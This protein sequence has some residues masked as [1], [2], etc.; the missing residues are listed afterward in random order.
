M[1]CKINKEARFLYFIFLILFFQKTNAAGQYLDTIVVSTDIAS[2]ISKKGILYQGIDNV[3]EISGVHLKNK[4]VFVTTSNGKAYLMD[5]KIYLMPRKKGFANVQVSWNNN[6]DTLYK[7]NKR[8]YVVAL[9]LPVLMVDNIKLQDKNSINREIFM[10][11]DSIHVFYGEDLL[12]ANRWATISHFVLGYAYGNNFMKFEFEGKK[13]PD[14]F[15]KVVSRIPPGKEVTLRVYLQYR[16]GITAS[17][18][19]FKTILY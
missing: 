9:P 12:V 5:N 6:T 3:L 7:V 17:V 16:N 19:N 15:R 4:E 8:F 10:N 18:K 13:I 1:R 2:L 11:C 14:R